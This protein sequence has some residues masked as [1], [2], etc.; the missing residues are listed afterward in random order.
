M[1]EDN[2]KVN[3]D[4]DVSIPIEK[5]RE[6]AKSRE[7]DPEE[8]MEN[9]EMKVPELIDDYIGNNIVYFLEKSN[10]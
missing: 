3:I 8:F 5:I 9:L 1:L 6:F 4:F 10:I 2:F 7:I